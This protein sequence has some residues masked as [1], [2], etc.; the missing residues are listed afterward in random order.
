MP[1]PWDDERSRAQSTRL[2]IAQS[3]W[4]EVL[5]KW[6]GE[7]VDEQVKAAAWGKV[8]TS[9]NVLADLVRQL[10]TH[11]LYGRR[12]AVRHKAAQVDAF[13]GPEGLLEHA[14]W[15]TRGQRLQFL[16]MCLGDMYVR[17]GISEGRMVY[18]FAY[19][20]DI[21][22]RMA[23]EDPTRI[24][25]LRELRVRMIDDAPA[26]VWEVHKISGDTGTFRIYEPDGRE[27]GRDLTAKLLGDDMPDGEGYPW[28]DED[29]RPQLP[30]VHYQ[31]ADTG[32]AWN[33]MLRAGITRG[34]LNAA[35]YATFAGQC[36]RHAT[37]SHVIIWGLD[38][39]GVVAS[40]GG[41]QGA[42]PV[43]H[44]AITPG[45]AAY[46][47][48]KEGQVPGVTE[49]GPGVN[50]AEVSA[51]A[52]GYEAGQA[53]R[54]GLPASELT[55]QSA[56]PSSAAALSISNEG[57][58]DVSAQVEPMFRRCDLAALRVAAMVARLGGLGVFPESGYTIAYRQIP[59]SP[60]EQ[61]ERRD[62]L[63]W[64]L[65][66]GLVSRVD[67][68]VELNPGTTRDDAIAALRQVQEDEAKI[69]PPKPNA[70]LPSNL[71]PKPSNLPPG[72]PSNLGDDGEE[73][74]EDE[75]T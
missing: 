46:H 47:N 22:T 18:R 16:T 59:R 34:T 35:M 53:V 15:Y 58:R 75:D 6:V 71:D 41:V 38:M 29:G 43:A 24:V 25:E 13:V 74:A 61:Q 10:T 11:G 30:Y 72:E 19:P 68:Y 2:E 8:D 56:N 28:T 9:V 17:F 49:V 27:L 3:Q 60:T 45:A 67:V 39:P 36:A 63:T 44:Q 14:G 5:D 62:E 4:D 32:Q 42:Q 7:H 66:Q 69:A 70:P 51:F 54:W 64:Q 23:D 65:D 1:T 52:T 40:Q 21:W 48:V 33:H 50:L 73:A 57:K 55:R 20:S 37:G 12:Q 26:Y 31:D